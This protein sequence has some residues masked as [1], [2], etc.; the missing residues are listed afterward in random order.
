[1][2]EATQAT[3]QALLQSLQD[4]SE[5]LER[6]QRE[7]GGRRRRVA[8]APAVSEVLPQ[9][10]QTPPVAP[11]QSWMANQLQLVG[12]VFPQ[13]REQARQMVERGE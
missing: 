6:A 2:D 8:Q 13:L 9:F 11:A 7:M 1:M 3:A 10:G 12:K 4:L 5:E